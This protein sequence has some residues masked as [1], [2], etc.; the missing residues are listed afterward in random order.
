MFYW[1]IRHTSHITTFRFPCVHVVVI[2]ECCVI[3]QVG[4][5]TALIDGDQ[6]GNRVDSA[7][8]GVY[9]LYAF[10]YVWLLFGG[11]RESFRPHIRR[12]VGC[13][14]GLIGGK[15]QRSLRDNS[16]TVITFVAPISCLSFIALFTRESYVCGLTVFCCLVAVFLDLHPKVRPCIRSGY[17]GILP[18]RASG[19]ERGCR[20]CIYC[21][22]GGIVEGIVRPRSTV[23]FL[24]DNTYLRTPSLASILARTHPFVCFQIRIMPVNGIRRILR[25]HRCTGWT[26]LT[27]EPYISRIAVFCC[28]V[29]VFLYLHPKIRVFFDGQ[30]RLILPVALV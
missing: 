9:R 23:T 11:V 22:C 1:I 27:R 21:L 13:H 7:G 16:V 15:E 30:Q 25:Q 10:P 3:Q 29:A 17:G 8:L 26:L 18:C 5:A 2:A 28:S 4:I 12:I 6:L 19:R 14:I 20:R 24:A